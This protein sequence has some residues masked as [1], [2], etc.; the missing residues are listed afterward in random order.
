MNRDFQEIERLYN[1]LK[2]HSSDDDSTGTHEIYAELARLAEVPRLE[3]STESEWKS[4][5]SHEWEALQMRPTMTIEQIAESLSHDAPVEVNALEV[6][7]YLKD[8]RE[9]IEYYVQQLLAGSQNP[10]DEQD[11]TEE[12]KAKADGGG[13]Y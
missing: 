10:G 8:A 2:S 6:E 12:S 4:L 7:I 1:E 5:S 11:I 13:L 9:R 3:E